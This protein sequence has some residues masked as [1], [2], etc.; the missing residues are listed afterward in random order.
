[1][2]GPIDRADCKKEKLGIVGRV[3]IRIVRVLWMLMRPV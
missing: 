2:G 1:M 3:V